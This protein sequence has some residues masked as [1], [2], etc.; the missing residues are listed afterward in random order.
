M[1]QEEDD[2]TPHAQVDADPSGLYLASSLLPRLFSEIRSGLDAGTASDDWRCVI[3]SSWR[4]SHWI[5][6]TRWDI[7]LL[8]AITT[9]EEQKPSREI[10]PLKSY[11]W[12]EP[13]LC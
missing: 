7:A 10:F 2:P 6:C 8:T 3:Y 1:F 4:I 5:E 13:I 11:F 12:E 9:D